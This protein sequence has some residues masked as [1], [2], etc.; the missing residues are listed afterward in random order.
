[1]VTLVRSVPPLAATAGGTVP[2]GSDSARVS[3]TGMFVSVTVPQLVT[4]TW[5]ATVGVGGST[6]AVVPGTAEVG[7]PQAVPTMPDPA[8]SPGVVDGTA[9]GTRPTAVMTSRW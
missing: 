1:M 5:A 6:V 7:S 4:V 9:G 2:G 3:V 8:W